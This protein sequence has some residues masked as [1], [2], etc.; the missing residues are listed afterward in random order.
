M[1]VHHTSFFSLRHLVYGILRVMKKSESTLLSR[2][3][4]ERR[5][6]DLFRLVKEN[7][8]MLR[9][10]RNAR[11]IK[12]FLVVFIFLGICGYG[13][14]LFEKYKLQVIEVQDRI[15]DLREHLQDLQ[16]LKGDIEQTIGSIQET[17]TDT[18]PEISEVTE[19]ET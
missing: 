1:I 11:A 19:S 8:K 13:Y 14:Y 7:N 16:E 18:D 2:E 10:D 17:F 6:D 12:T 5:L 9:G 4:R 3:R 15:E